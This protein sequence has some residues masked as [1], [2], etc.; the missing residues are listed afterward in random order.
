MGSGEGPSST[1]AE[2]IAGCEDVGGIVGLSMEVPSE[3]GERP[4]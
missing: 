2:E 4:R 1:G 3:N